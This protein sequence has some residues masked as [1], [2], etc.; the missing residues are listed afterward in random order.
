MTGL[1]GLSEAS[2]CP[3]PLKYEVASRRLLPTLTSSKGSFGSHVMPP[4]SSIMVDIGFIMS[5]LFRAPSWQLLKMDQ[6]HPP[7]E[8]AD[9]I[10]CQGHLQSWLTNARE[11]S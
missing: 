8:E 7:A 1:E 5:E 6:C 9:A 10:S 4:A 2:S 3:I 11:L